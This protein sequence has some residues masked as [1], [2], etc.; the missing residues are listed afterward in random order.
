MAGI[1]GHSLPPF[2]WGN[3]N[4]NISSELNE[5]DEVVTVLEYYDIR[6]QFV[7]GPYTYGGNERMP[8]SNR[9]PIVGDV[10]RSF[11]D[12]FYERVHVLPSRIELGTIANTQSRQV[13]VWNAYTR[14]TATLDEIS[15]TNGAGISVVGPALPL[16]FQPLQELFWEI[17]ITPNGPPQINAQILFDF[18]NVTDP[19][20]VVVIGSRAVVMPAVPEVPVVEKWSWLTDVKVSVDGTEQR[21]GLREVPRRRLS[22][23]LQFDT[24]ADLR[25]QYKTLLGAAGRLFVPYFQYSSVLAT[26][27]TAGDATLLFDTGAVDLRDE[28]Y[29][30]ILEANRATL[31]QT[32][33][34]GTQSVTL[35]APLSTNLSKGARVVGVFPSMLPNNLTMSR[36]N[37]NTVGSLSLQSDATYPRSSH[38][39]PGNRISLRLFQGSPLIEQRP[40]ME[41]IDHEF[42]TGQSV[43]DAKTGLVDMSVDWDYTRV[44]QDLRFR[45]RRVGPASCGWM[46]GTDNMDYW[47]EFTDAVRGSLKVFYVSSFRA[48]QVLAA[49]V[50]VGADSAIL[51]GPTYA[52][53]FFGLGP[54]DQ[55]ALTTAAGV[56][57]AKV[58]A[59][60][61]DGDGNTAVTF[62]PSLPAGVGWNAIEMVS[63]LFKLRIADDAV[64][65]EH[66]P[67]DTV[68]GFKTRTATE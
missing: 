42:D 37:V 15:I 25:E 49:D 3:T 4:L 41:D 35:K 39:R 11:K 46:T 17:R 65:L 50:G 62:T 36:L 7:V 32:D 2:V 44:E 1:V 64:R 48:D 47:R 31:I 16:V 21:I 67:L 34:I 27:A 43:G 23:Q 56:H 13:S 5:L 22:S 59:A 45:V 33:T 28:D 52:E 24:E 14:V 19:V 57:Y 55:L 38:V 6:Y 60:A 30:L 8:L 20:P 40:Q 29:I 63:Y 53:N 12:D 68:I 26:A 51:L 10:M 54:Y 9:W 58:V 61:K 18:S 66:W